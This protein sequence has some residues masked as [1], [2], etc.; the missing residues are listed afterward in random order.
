M[1]HLLDRNECSFFVFE[2]QKNANSFTPETSSGWCWTATRLTHPS[3]PELTKS[4]SNHHL[5]SVY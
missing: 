3:C 4:V 5:K 1:Q 2:H